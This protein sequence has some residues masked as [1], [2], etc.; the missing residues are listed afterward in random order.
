M[1]EQSEDQR[2][3]ACQTAGLFCQYPTG[4]VTW[5]RDQKSSGAPRHIHCHQYTQSRLNVLIAPAG[6]AGPHG[7][8]S[9][10]PCVTQ[11]PVA[12]GTASRRALRA[13]GGAQML[14]RRRSICTPSE[15]RGARRDVVP[16]VTGI[17][18]THGTRESRPCSPAHP[19]GAIRTFR[20]VCVYW[21]QWMCRGAPLDFW[22]LSQGTSPVGY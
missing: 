18:V 12:R 9:H 14:R 10:V 7:R 16:R 4:L 17:C 20:R 2:N 11:I 21:W 19:A 1:R 22:S 15:A 8:D 5:E 3:D 13:S 6:W